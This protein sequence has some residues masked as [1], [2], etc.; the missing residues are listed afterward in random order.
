MWGTL[1][2]IRPVNI[3]T[4]ILEERADGI[5]PYD[6]VRVD[7]IRPYES[8]RGIKDVMGLSPITEIDN[9]IYKENEEI[10]EYLKKEYYISDEK[11]FELIKIARNELNSR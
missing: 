3:V 9:P 7:G 2:G 4:S 8:E 11:A 5:R 10:K 1:T 6:D